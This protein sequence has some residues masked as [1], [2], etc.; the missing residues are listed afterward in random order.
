MARKKK[1]SRRPAATAAPAAASPFEPDDVAPGVG[2]YG[3]ET[4]GRSVV[5]VLDDSPNAMKSVLAALKKSAGVSKVCRM[6]DFQTEAFDAQDTQDADAIVFDELN[7]AIV[8]GDGGRTAAMTTMASA[9]D[10]GIIVEPEYVN[11]AFGDAG[12]DSDLLDGGV[13]DDVTSGTAPMGPMGLSIDYLHGYQQAVNA[14][15]Q[16]LT[17]GRGLQAGGTDLVGLAGEVRDTAAA[18]WGL[19]AT[20][21]LQSRFSGRGIRVAVLDTG[22]DLRH[23]DFAGRLLSTRSFIPGESVQDGNG[24]GTHCIGTS[25]GAVRPGVGPRYGIAH[26]AQIF[27]GK[28]LSNAGSGNDGGI[29]QGI[30]WALQNRCQVIS[31]SLGRPVA[32]GERPMSSY[33]IAGRRALDAGCLIVAAAGN[34]SA[35]PSVVRPVSSPAN[36]STI[37]G[38]AAIDANLRIASFSNRGINP[39]G[40]EVNIAGPGVGVLSSWPMPQRLRSISGTSM[41]TPHVA[42]IAALIAQEL[43]SARGVQLYRELWRRARRLPH[44]FADVGNGLVEAT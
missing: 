24:H 28:V 18:T 11:Y 12:L 38:V 26:E 35:R 39:A 8:P 17:G 34:D 5:T 27:A 31:M 3:A 43:P 41:A 19:Q 32:V 33:E 1:A 9:G 4:T 21:V 23:P 7:I 15:V 2:E 6:S 30:N 16:S 29:L 20:R 10:A 36:A 37:V 44:S 42:G 40:G 22:I 25:C 14:L 13:L